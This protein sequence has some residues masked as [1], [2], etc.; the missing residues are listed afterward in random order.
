MLWQSYCSA[1]DAQQA[2]KPKREKLLLKPKR[3]TPHVQKLKE[4]A[5]AK[6][7]EKTLKIY[8][9]FKESEKQ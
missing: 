9:R 7:R 3:E 6:Q 1:K 4:Q 2:L 5:A 8:R